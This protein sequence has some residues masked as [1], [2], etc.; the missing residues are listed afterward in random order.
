[1]ARRP[2]RS[3]ARTS[4]RLSRRSSAHAGKR[5]RTTKSASRPARSHSLLRA[6]S[7]QDAASIDALFDAFA[8]NL[9]RTLSH[10]SVDGPT[11][12]KGE[13]GE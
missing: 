10:R 12:A 2:V 13:G 9:A 8:R 11:P 1:M 7:D 6:T 4:T 3:S 5:K